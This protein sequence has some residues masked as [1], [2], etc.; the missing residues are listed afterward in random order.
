MPIA[1]LRMF[2]K[3]RRI[4]ASD[5]DAFTYPLYTSSWSRPV[6]RRYSRTPVFLSNTNSITTG[7][8]KM[9]VDME[10]IATDTSG[11]LFIKSIDVFSRVIKSAGMKDGIFEKIAPK[12]DIAI[13]KIK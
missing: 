13:P 10:T 3:A 8:E 6:E 1:V 12:T 9:S 4:L 11:M 2:E 7:V 5:N